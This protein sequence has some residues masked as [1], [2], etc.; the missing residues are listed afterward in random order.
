MNGYMGSSNLGKR[1]TEGW[2]TE[3][4]D[5]RSGCRR[6]FRAPSVSTSRPVPHF[7]CPHLPH[8]TNKQHS[9]WSIRLC[10]SRILKRV[11][12]PN[13]LVERLPRLLPAEPGTGI[14]EHL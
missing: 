3:R 4:R 1:I 5:S 7:L 9:V 6:T 2:L 14:H 8:L 12:L 13:S 11:W 10:Y